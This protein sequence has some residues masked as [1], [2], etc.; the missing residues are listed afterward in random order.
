MV[1]SLQVYSFLSLA[2]HFLHMHNNLRYLLSVIILFVVGI[3]IFNF[4]NRKQEANTI[5][6]TAIAGDSV[7]T[8]QLDLAKAY[9]EMGQKP[10]A[11]QILK[12]SYRKGSAAQKKA[13]RQLLKA[14]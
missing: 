7:V 2:F 11:K 9:I 6:F 14:L 5:D 13:A 3:L 10:L 8:T 12:Q 4:A 1:F